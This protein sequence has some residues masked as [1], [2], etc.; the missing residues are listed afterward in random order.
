LTTLQP[1]APRYIVNP[2][3]STKSL[4]IADIHQL[5]VDRP[6]KNYFNSV[7]LGTVNTLLTAPHRIAVEIIWPLFNFRL[8]H[9]AI[10]SALV[11]ASIA[12]LMWC[13]LKG[14]VTGVDIPLHVAVNATTLTPE[15]GQQALE[16][17]CDLVVLDLFMLIAQDAG[18]LPE[19]TVI[20]GFPANEQAG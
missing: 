5:V 15:E 16:E 2:A 1:K 19:G 11:P 9:A 13:G 14:C 18:L 17:G 7:W 3:A 8:A 20:P 4:W 6:N 12:M 10:S